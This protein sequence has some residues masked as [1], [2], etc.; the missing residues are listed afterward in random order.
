MLTELRHLILKVTHV[1]FAPGRIAYDNLSYRLLFGLSSLLS[2]STLSAKKKCPTPPANHLR[3]RLKAAFSS[4]AGRRSFLGI[5]EQSAKALLLKMPVV[6]QNFG[7]TFPA[8]GLHGNTISQAV[9][10]IGTSFVQSQAL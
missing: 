9:G 5:A 1:V 6:R 10:F 3:F 8:H 7:Q 2:G 4:S